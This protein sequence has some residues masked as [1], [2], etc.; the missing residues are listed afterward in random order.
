MVI[1]DRYARDID[2]SRRPVDRWAEESPMFSL[3]LARSIHADRVRDAEASTDRRAIVRTRGTL[4]SPA[5]AA[6]GV[7]APRVARGS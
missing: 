5:R 2:R 7:P 3:E 4:T 6:K 1:N